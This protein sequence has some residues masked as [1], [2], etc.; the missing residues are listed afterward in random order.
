MCFVSAQAE[1]KKGGQ[2]RDIK[3][4]CLFHYFPHLFILQTDRVAGLAPN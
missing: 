4:S 3:M 2:H 1:A